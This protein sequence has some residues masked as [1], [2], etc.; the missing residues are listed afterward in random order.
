MGAAKVMVNFLHTLSAL[1]AARLP[2]PLLYRI[3]LLLRLV[4]MNRRKSVID[5]EL[6]IKISSWLYG[7]KE[8]H[9][10]LLPKALSL[11]VTDDG[12]GEY[13]FPD[14]VRFLAERGALW[15]CC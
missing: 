15:R 10:A 11:L 6:R 8:Q 14:L 1:P 13:L 5:P 12:T 3:L 2:P 9:G 4:E 7:A